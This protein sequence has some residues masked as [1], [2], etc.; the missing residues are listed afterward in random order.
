LLDKGHRKIGLVSGEFNPVVNS[1]RYLGYCQAMTGRGL[2]VETDYCQVPL[3]QSDDIYSDD[4]Y[5]FLKTADITAIYLLNGCFAVPLFSAIQRLGMRVPED[6]EIMCFDDV[7][8][9]YPIYRYPFS[10]VKMPLEKMG[11][12]AAEYLLGKFEHGKDIPVLKKLYKAELVSCGPEA[13][14]DK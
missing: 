2:A 13:M 14:P 4:I 9:T 1:L 3:N 7:G 11:R 10:Y 12:D 8:Y 6:L 5:E